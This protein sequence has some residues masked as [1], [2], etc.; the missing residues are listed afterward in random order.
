M[1]PR[2]KEAIQ[3]RLR[4]IW[5]SLTPTER[6]N[7]QLGSGGVSA[8]A[9]LGAGAGVVDWATGEENVL[10]SG[11]LL[12]NGIAVGAIP[13]TGGIGGAIG[14]AASDRYLNNNPDASSQ[15]Y[16]E[17]VSN[18]KKDLRGGTW[19]TTADREGA[20]QKFADEKK[21]ASFI[22]NDGFIPEIAM[23]EARR[24]KPDLVNP[25]LFKGSRRAI[26]T[27]VGAG[28]GAG[29]GAL[30]ASAYMF[31]DSQPSADPMT[32]PQSITSNIPMQQLQEISDLLG[33]NGAL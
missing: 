3:N 2:Q 28:I 20:Q 14:Y 21:A 12:A 23:A 26:G 27:A 8:A 25:S 9:A 31:N 32:Q 33:A 10:N 24:Q 7:I 18:A 15:Y 19:E 13:F 1:D 30:G 11:E 6:R 29:I 5:D 22:A 4:E 17:R 16:N